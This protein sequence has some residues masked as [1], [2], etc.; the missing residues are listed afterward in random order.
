MIAFQSKINYKNIRPI[1]AYANVL[2]INNLLI[3]CVLRQEKINIKDIIIEQISPIDKRQSRVSN[4]KFNLAF[5]R[6]SEIMGNT[7]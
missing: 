7:K 3:S 5:V 6:H 4:F 2:T 1:D